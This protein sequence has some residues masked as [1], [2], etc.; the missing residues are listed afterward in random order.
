MQETHAQQHLLKNSFVF[1]L[2]RIIFRFGL[3][4]FGGL[5]VSGSENIPLTGPVLICPN[6][7]SD[8]DP[9]V[10]CAGTD[11]PDLNAL[12][13]SE[14]FKVPVLG[15]YFHLIGATPVVRDSPDRAAI[16][17]AEAI[18]NA[19]RMLLIF[20]EGRTS[21]SGELADIQMGA[22]MLSLKTCAPIIPVGIRGSTGILSYGKVIPH[23]SKEGVSVT[24]GKPINPKDYEEMPHRLAQKTMTDDLR[25]AISHLLEQK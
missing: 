9:V 12:A 13:K 24:F 4:F 17:T 5:K 16:R 23:Y 1:K 14:L 11:R 25:A 21:P 22:A 19:G 20:P 10:I 6:H 15:K 2:S 8:L 3:P 7:T 18:L